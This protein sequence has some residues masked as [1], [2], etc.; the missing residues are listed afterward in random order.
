MSQWA[1]RG[2]V[3]PACF[4]TSTGWVRRRLPYRYP[5]PCI[6]APLSTSC[7]C[8]SSLPH[9]HPNPHSTIARDLN[10]PLLNP[11]HHPCHAPSIEAQLRSPPLPPKTAIQIPP[12]NG[13]RTTSPLSSMSRH[14]CGM[15]QGWMRGSAA[16]A[17]L[18]VSGLGSE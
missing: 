11:F 7:I 2:R 8:S 16:A 13:S 6:T 5:R 15:F 17:R 4:G 18:G 12:G 14:T 3:R 9:H 10:H 1:G